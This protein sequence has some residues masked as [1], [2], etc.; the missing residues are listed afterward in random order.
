ME[1]QIKLIKR[2][3]LFDCL[4]TIFILIMWFVADMA[5]HPLMIGFWGA[6]HALG[7]YREYNMMCKLEQGEISL[8]HILKENLDERS[9]SKSSDREDQ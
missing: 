2:F 7:A 9:N 4:I 3:C 1:K 5:L 8:E 6:M